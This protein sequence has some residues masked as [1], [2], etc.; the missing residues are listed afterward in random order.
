MWMLRKL[1]N[2]YYFFNFL[3]NATLLGAI[4]VPFFTQWGGISLFQA[5]LLQSWFTLWIFILEVPTGA[6]ADKIGRKHSMAL[7][8]LVTAVGVILYGSIPHFV[9]FLVAEW[10]FALGVALMS[11]A[12]EAWMYDTLKQ[13]NQEKQATHYFG[14]AR[15]WALVGILVGSISGGIVAETFGLQWPMML[16]S[17]PLALSAFIAWRLPEPSRSSQHLQESTRYLDYFKAGLTHLRSSKPLQALLINIVGVGTAAYFVIWFYQPL[18]LMADIP[19][20]W[21]GFFHAGLVA[22]EMIVTS[23]FSRLTRWFGG[24]ARYITMTAMVTSITF[25]VAA[26]WPN[27]VTTL[28]L[29]IFAGGFGLTRLDYILPHAHSLIHSGNR[30]STASSLSMFR[31]LGQ[32]VMNPVVGAVADHSLRL[33]LLLVGVFPLISVAMHA[34]IKQIVK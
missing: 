8:A 9:N 31:R 34:K 23:Q 26:I 24:S 32:A 19:I 15:S 2:R 7:G 11:G 3:H 29:L 22:V 4:L 14:K 1:I 27:L 6:V 17:I 10:L 30:A 33:A 18:L 20:S 12:D 28:L 21:F 13:H 25:I 5:Q 16:S